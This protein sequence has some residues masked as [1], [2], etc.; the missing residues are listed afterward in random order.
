MKK[1]EISQLIKEELNVFKSKEIL[2][3]IELVNPT[4]LRLAKSGRG[5]YPDT[6]KLTDKGVELILSKIK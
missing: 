2:G 4:H 3:D 5:E 6:Y 1:S